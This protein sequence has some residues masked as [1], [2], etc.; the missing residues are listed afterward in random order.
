MSNERVVKRNFVAKVKKGKIDSKNFIGRIKYNYTQDQRE[1]ILEKLSK[2]YEK[3]AYNNPLPIN[4]FEICS[5]EG[6]MYNNSNVKIELEWYFDILRKYVKE[7]NNFLNLSN[8]IEISILNKTAEKSFDLIDQIENKTCCSLYSVQTEMYLNE[9]LGDYEANNLLIKGFPIKSSPLKFIILLDF[10]RLRL[11]HNMSFWQYDSIIDQHKKQYSSDSKTLI[12]YVDYKVNPVR[13]EK[14]LSELTFIVFFDSDFSIIDRYVSIKNLLS[15][16]LFEN[17]RCDVE[18]K[19]IIKKNA[20]AFS[21]L[22]TD[23][24][25]QKLLLL[26]DDNENNIKT[27]VTND[28]YIKIQDLFFNGEYEKVVE[29]CTEILR[30]EPN[31]SDLYIFYVKSIILLNKTVSN[32]FNESNDLQ[33]ILNMI[34]NILLKKDSYIS[35]RDKLLDKYY[36]IQHFSFSSVILEFL[37][38]EYRLDIPKGVKYLTYLNSRVFRYNAYSLFQSKDFLK[39]ETNFKNTTLDFIRQN[40]SVDKEEKISENL[41]FQLK[42]YVE[43]LNYRKRYDLVIEELENYRSNHTIVIENN[44]FIETWI[45][46]TLLKCNYELKNFIQISIHLVDRYFKNRI[47]YDHFFDEKF[48]D[49]FGESNLSTNISI[50]ILFEIYKQ[51]Q[52]SIYDRLAD[53]LIANEI[54][55][56]SELVKIKNQFKMDHLIYFLGKV[57]TKDNIQDSPFLNSIEALELER[58]KILNILKELNENDIESYNLEILNLTKEASL[59]KGLLQIHESRIYV[60]TNNITKYLEIELPDIFER[61]LEFNDLT[62]SSITTFKLDEKLDEN[63]LLV[64]FYLLDP[65]PESELILYLTKKDPRT[66]PNAVT[67]PIIRYTYFKN[68]FDTIQR[69]FIYSEDYGFK[70]FLSMR[71]R[72]GTFNNVLRSVFDKYNLISFKDSYNDDYEEIKFWNDK[73]QVEFET[74]VLI[75]DLLK[76]FSK[77]IDDLIEKGLSWLNIKKND[78]NKASHHIFDFNFNQNEMYFIYHNRLGKIKDYNSFLN[79]TF[80]ILYERLE[81]S[82]RSLR[83]KISIEFAN[84]FLSIL[85]ELQSNI[86]TITREEDQV[87]SIKQNIISCGTDIQSTLN[88]ITKWFNISKNQY[89]EEFPIDMILQNSLDYIN[90]IHTNS[91]SNS[92]VTKNINCSSRFKGKY[93]ESF[94]DILINIFEN[95]VSKNRD[96]GNDLKIEISIKEIKDKIVI[97]VSNTLS[98]SIDKKKLKGRIIKIKEN[99]SNYKKEGL[100]SSFE[101]GSGY[102][103]I[104]KSIS[105]DLERKEYIVI[106]KIIKNQFEVEIQ[107]DLKEL[108]I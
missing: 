61:Y 27:D 21:E 56:P 18:T 108:I 102:L 2:N 30:E 3:L 71:I 94:G 81:I 82:L 52:S 80:E 107:F 78:E 58:I 99:V 32:V 51:P 26:I 105:V 77:K 101:E 9:E 90:T 12:D 75:Q 42:V 54:L 64:T 86:Q 28:L 95:V 22:F 66:D 11:D 1:Y 63:S 8:K 69:E 73:I 34:Y 35:D 87:N 47:A 103:K 68:I 93:F 57:C 38:N 88:Q 74:R 60:D 92:S 62:Y 67:V 4:E 44:R 25:W 5:T 85:D 55:K 83:Q 48:I 72:H 91:I 23:C 37:Y 43:V 6:V 10:A 29:Y 33:N 89:I 14:N 49:N 98:N 50:P 13:F 7:I 16:I 39:I 79:E 41:F 104:C 17:D 19:A 36:K 53:F 20:Q 65:L 59:R 45:D 40:L 100:A 70:S 46:K 97:V 15:I 76:D 31:L 84:S 106:P 24:Y 96:L